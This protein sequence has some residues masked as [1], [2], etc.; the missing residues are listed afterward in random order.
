MLAKWHLSVGK[1]RPITEQE[2]KDRALYGV[3]WTKSRVEESSHYVDV[4]DP[5]DTWYRGQQ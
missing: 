3:Y 1:R 2:D 5:K 4:E